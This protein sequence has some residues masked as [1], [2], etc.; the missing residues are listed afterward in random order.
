MNAICVLTRDPAELP[1]PSAAVGERGVCPLEEGPPPTRWGADPGLAASRTG[2]STFLLC[3][4]TQ[5]AVSCDNSL[6]AA[7]SSNDES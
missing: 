4:G 5:S 7:T 1:R 3:G 2:S 6:T